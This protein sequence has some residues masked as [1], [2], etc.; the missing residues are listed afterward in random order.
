[1]QRRLLRDGQIATD[2]WR[3]SR[4]RRLMRARRSYRHVG[5]VA[6][7]AR[8]VAGTRQPVRIVLS[9][10]HHVEQ[11]APDLSHF[12]LIAAQFPGPGEDAAIP[13]HGSAARPLEFQGRTAR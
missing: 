5:S 9:P 11:L 1:M 8:H 4:G 2:D 6:A 10:E 13:R 3:Y 7:G 12:E